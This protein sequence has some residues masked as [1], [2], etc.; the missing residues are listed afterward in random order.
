M[1]GGQ[2][3]SEGSRCRC[4]RGEAGVPRSESPLDRTDSP[5]VRFAAELRQLRKAAGTPTYRALAKHAHYSATTLSNAAG[6]RSLPSLAVTLAYAQACGGNHGEWEQRW[7]TTVAEIAAQNDGLHTAVPHDESTAPYVG[8]AAFQ[9]EDAYRFFGRDRLVGELVA[10]VGRQR[11]TAVFGPS[12]CGKSS[13]LRAGL[14]AAAG[15]AGLNGTPLPVLLFSPGTDPFEECAVRLAELVGDSPCTLKAEFRDDP[16]SLHLRIRQALAGWPEEADLL[17]VVD[18]FEE[19]FT[20]CT[21]RDER[22]RF[23]AALLTAAGAANSRARIVLGVRADFYGHC[24]QNP[25]LADALR[26]AQ[27]MVGPMSGEELREAVTRPAI[28]AGYSVESPLL[29]A[30]VADATGQPGALPLVSHAMA[31]TWRRRSGNRLTVDGYRAAGGIR[32]AVAHSAEAAYQALSPAQQDLARGIFLRLTALGEGTEDTKRRIHRRELDARPDTTAVV[33]ALAARR[34]LTLDRDW[35]DITHEALIGN[36]PRLG[37]WLTE[38]RN[39]LRIHRRL[40]DATDVWE[41]GQR[42]EHS[43]LRG[44]RLEAATEWADAHEDLLTERERRFLSESRAAATAVEAATRRR[45]RRLWQLLALLTAALMVAVTSAVLAAR[46]RQATIDERDAALARQASAASA[47]IR[48]SNPALAAQL[49]LAA[50]RLAPTPETRDGLLSASAT[51]YAAPLTGHT[52]DLVSLAFSPTG[53]VLATAGWDRAV[54][55]W[56][57][58]DPRRPRTL[59]VIRR[60]GAFHAVAFDRTGDV[61]ATADGDEV[62]L[63]DVTDTRNPRVLGTLTDRT[64]A[65][66][67]VALS[68]DGRTMATAGQDRTAELWDV[69]DPHRPRRLAVLRGH[70]DSLTSVAFSSDGRL[71]ATTGDTTVR[72]WDVSDPHAPKKQGVLT[73]HTRKVQ[74]AA[75]SPDGHTLATASWDHTVRVWDITR[76]TAP[77]SLATLTGHTALVWSVAFSPDGRT[78]ASTGG[79][80]LLWDMSDPRRPSLLTDLPNGVYSAAFSPDGT[81]LA[82][83]SV[84]HDLRELPLFR[85]GDVIDTVA[86]S[87]DGRILAS[88]S[89]DNTVRLWDVTPGRPRLLL[90]TLTGQRDFIR[91]VAFS[92]DG[93]TLATASNDGTVWLWNVRDPRDARQLSVIEPHAGEVATASFSPDGRTLATAGLRTVRLW[94]VTDPDS[95]RP[96]ARLGGYLGDGGAAVF[97][98]DGRTL[99]TGSNERPSALWDITDPRRPRTR[100]FAFSADSVRPGSFS[101]DGRLLATVNTADNTVRLLDMT[102]P[103][104]PRQLALL[105]GYTHFVYAL[106]FAPDGR[107]LATGD[108]GTRAQVWDVRD[109]RRPR[110]LADLAGNE[111]AVPAVTFSPDGHTLAAGGNDHTLR[112]W[113][114]DIDRATARVCAVASP[115]LTRGEWE[116]Y[117]PGVRYHPPCP[118]A[119]AG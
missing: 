3:V 44:T 80:T 57:V 88:G 7:H 59:T 89:W 60:P 53:S 75:F 24:A 115:S 72:L 99:A 47:D 68:P 51:P 52:S 36:W 92:P 29:A 110:E 112:L 100:D 96:L 78:L 6:G 71:L 93:R 105:T 45:T 109:P 22:D 91:S 27:V 16:G 37:N 81:M 67:W 116:H 65:V 82:A 28:G 118:A 111:L 1:D 83:G 18:Q 9:P 50:Y 32:H 42:D 5:L 34:L 61:L 38:D 113:E 46:A 12:G 11:L 63:W 103:R 25:D 87:P 21:G 73:G 104:H 74:S 64:G 97:S 31:E 14:V 58:R 94:D 70:S 41:S 49:G 79:G 76:P 17:I 40:T 108:G 56:D 35:L 86:F 62:V 26:D 69:G 55:L 114:T 54:R 10:K 117:L 33:E 15:K 85:H 77:R 106:A 39:G 30:V 98:P 48:G 4:L 84:L 102:D 23:V 101:P 43:L 8:L 107:R 119:P 66:T 13:L 20:L 90:A 95:P 19:V 2:R